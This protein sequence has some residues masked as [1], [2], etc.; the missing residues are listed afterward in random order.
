MSAE[1]PSYPPRQH[2]LRDLRIVVDRVGHDVVARL[3][4]S[5]E[6][7]DSTGRTRVGVLATLVDVIAGETAIRSVLPSWTAT[8]N[9]A[10]YVDEIPLS[11]PIEVTSQ[12]L[13]SG[14]QT[15]ILEV[16]LRSGRDGREIGV[17]QIGF[18]ILP[19][20]ND[21]QSSGHWA[22]AP[23]ARTDFATP[24][25]GFNEPI[26][27]TMGLI[28]DPEDAAI[29]RLPTVPPYLINSL[30][31]LQGGAVAILV[32]AAAE[33]FAAAR[34]E[35][36][37]RVRSLVIQY[38]KLGRVGPIRAESRQIARTAGG[39]LVHVTLFDQ[40]ADDALLTVATIQVDEASPV[41]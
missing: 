5:P 7:V 2:L 34:L 23:E 33:H 11:D 27:E 38:L 9:L 21:V 40:G 26:L 39:L 20:R 36:S 13:R 19:A 3:E 16:E 30:G 31:A 35:G 12:I 22:E 14:R 32:E 37:V 41:T 24:D 1:R 15:V 10:V 18:A 25:S 28:F 6:I 29:A 4:P 17:A 8:S